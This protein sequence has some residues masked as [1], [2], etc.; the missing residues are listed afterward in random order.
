LSSLRHLCLAHGEPD[1][2]VK[3]KLEPGS[4]FTSLVPTNISSD[5]QSTELLLEP[6]LT[7]LA[8][9][10]TRRSVVV[11]CAWENMMMYIRSGLAGDC[12]KSLESEV[13][14]KG[15]ESLCHPIWLTNTSTNTT[16]RTTKVEPKEEKT[17]AAWASDWLRWRL[18]GKKGKKHWLT[19]K[20]WGIWRAGTR[21]KSP[22]K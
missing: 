18:A 13:R 20:R 3:N 7:L 2:P 8:N 22:W 15:N 11:S 1:K 21:C 17:H 5:F 6:Q 14:R 9:M 19:W 4:K 12:K 16:R 10:R